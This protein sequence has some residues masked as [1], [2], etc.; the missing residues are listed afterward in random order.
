[1]LFIAKTS[2]NRKK[3][4]YKMDRRE[5]SF[6]PSV[7]MLDLFLVFLM[8]LFLF[9]TRFPFIYYAPQLLSQFIIIHSLSLFSHHDFLLLIHIL[10]HCKGKYIS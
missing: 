9:I 4:V 8:G 3:V 10:G 7:P 6:R 5:Y 2:P 1:M